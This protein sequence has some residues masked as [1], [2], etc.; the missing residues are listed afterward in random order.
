MFANRIAPPQV[1]YLGFAGTSGADFYDCL[2]ADQVVFPPNDRPHYTEFVS[3]LLNSFFSADTSISIDSLGLFP[4]REDHGLLVDGLVFAYFNNFYKITPS[5]FDTRI[6]LLKSFPH[7]VLWLSKFSDVATKNLVNEAL[8]R[9]VDSSRLIFAELVPSRAVYLSRLRLA[10]LFLDA[11]NY[12]AH[13]TAADA[14]WAGLPVLT[15]IG[16]TFAGRVAASQLSA[17]GLPELI[18]F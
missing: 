16:S 8:K 17:L 6:K 10:D 11:P 12:N 2:I 9:G 7:S 13:T 3:Y 1:N 4:K 15:Q 14:L 5:V 18:T